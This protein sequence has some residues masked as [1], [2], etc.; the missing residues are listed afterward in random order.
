[1]INISA[2]SED[3]LRIKNLV[4][5][6][7][8]GLLPEEEKLGQRFEVDVEVYGDFRGYSN[9]QTESAV[10]YPEI[11]KLTE[12]VV[13]EERFGLIEALADRVADVLQERLGLDR[14]LV[15]VRKPNPPFDMQFDGVEVEIRRGLAR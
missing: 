6:G 15:R 12:S 10:D 4:F 11:C 13:T 1:M 3:I 9:G 8:H 5:Y 2:M 14:F 7:Y